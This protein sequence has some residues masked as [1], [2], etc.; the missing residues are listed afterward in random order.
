M[1]RQ[2]AHWEKF[3]FVYIL[4]LFSYATS[5]TI[6]VRL[7]APYYV[8]YGSTA[9]LHC[10]HNVSDDN[11]RRIEFMKDDKKIFEYVKE[12]NPQY[13]TPGVDG[14]KME[15]QR[16]FYINSHVMYVTLPTAYDANIFETYNEPCTVVGWG[17]HIPGSNEGT[18]TYLRHVHI[19]LI[20]TDRCPVVGMD[21]K[22]HL[23]AGVLEGG[24][25]A[26]QGD[27]GGPLLCKGVQVGIVSWGKG[28]ARAN[29]PGVY[30]RL[31]LYLCWINETVRMNNAPYNIFNIEIVLIPIVFLVL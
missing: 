2:S 15:L 11:L 4:Q 25:D 3:V 31:D 9:I 24:K 5:N 29:S 7:A 1:P 17:R 28:C 10:K 21:T 27:S 26:C 16:P 12:R 30:S 20:P 13:L 18:G 14:A 23:C 19:S 22:L 8:T 6:Y